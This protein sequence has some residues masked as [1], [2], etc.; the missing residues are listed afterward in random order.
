M[1]DWFEQYWLTVIM[2]AML[3]VFSFLVRRFCVEQ[4]NAFVKLLKEIESEHLQQDD[5][6]NG[7]VSLLHNTLFQMCQL[8]IL[9]NY[10]TVD[11][12]KTLKALFESYSKLGGNGTA[13]ELYDRCLKLEII[14]EQEIAVIVQKKEK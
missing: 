3:S 12:L 4:K 14:T 13:K 11:E 6:K 9:N 1:I 2:G 7:L 5:I 10:I 8:H